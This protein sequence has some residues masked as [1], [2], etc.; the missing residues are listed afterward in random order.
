MN[1]VCTV[2]SLMLQAVMAMSHVSTMEP[3]QRFLVKNGY[4]AGVDV[5]VST[6][7]GG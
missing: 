7:G 1:N 3:L 2:L 6:H 4:Q 5:I